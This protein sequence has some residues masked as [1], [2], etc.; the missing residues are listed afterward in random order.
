GPEAAH[1]QVLWHVDLHA[2]A[3]P[4]EDLGALPI[5]DQVVEG[6]QQR[7]AFGL[8]RTRSREGEVRAA[9]ARDLDAP[10]DALAHEALQGV[11]RHEATERVDATQLLQGRYTRRRERTFG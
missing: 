5:D 6:R 7:G 1:S 4:E 8:E 2:V 3:H 10:G 9:Q 11:F